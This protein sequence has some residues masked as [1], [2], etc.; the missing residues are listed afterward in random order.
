M[1]QRNTFESTYPH[2][3]FPMLVEVGIAITK[4]FTRTR[5]DDAAPKGSAV[6]HAQ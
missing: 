3:P 6:A 4:L 2:Y 5:R 1:S